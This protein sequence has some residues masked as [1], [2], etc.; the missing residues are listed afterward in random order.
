MPVF[1]FWPPKFF[2]LE[3]F[4][5]N[6]D[7]RLSGNVQNSPTVMCNEDTPTEVTSY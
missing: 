2:P 6:V 3:I 4:D 5:Y 7:Q 1:P